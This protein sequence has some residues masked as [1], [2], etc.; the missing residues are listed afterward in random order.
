LD[1]KVVYSNE[2]NELYKH[3][4]HELNAIQSKLESVYQELSE[5][6]AEL[7]MYKNDFILRSATF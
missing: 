3:T 7:Q 1:H 2:M 4:T 6:K 5:T